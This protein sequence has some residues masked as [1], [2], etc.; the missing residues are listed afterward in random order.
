MDRFLLGHQGTMDFQESFGVFLG[1]AAIWG[2]V[3]WKS[4]KP[5]MS[6][7]LQYQLL[8]FAEKCSRN[9]LLTTTIMNGP[10]EN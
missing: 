3:R 4:E 8:H 9:Q 1:A 6:Y 5:A 7:R 2:L 10:L